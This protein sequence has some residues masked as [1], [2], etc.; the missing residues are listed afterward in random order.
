MT[1]KKA[2]D[3]QVTI[4]LEV[5]CL[6]YDACDLPQWQ[7][8]ERLNLAILHTICTSRFKRLHT[9]REVQ[10]AALLQGV[11]WLSDA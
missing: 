8:L 3:D 2:D 6:C 11:D 9:I 1:N 7:S 10:G 4:V 5:I